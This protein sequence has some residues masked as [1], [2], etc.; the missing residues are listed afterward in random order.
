MLILSFHYS[1]NAQYNYSKDYINTC[2]VTCINAT[3]LK[4]ADWAKRV[5]SCIVNEMQLSYSMKTAKEW[6]N[7]ERDEHLKPF[8]SKCRNQVIKEII[9]VSK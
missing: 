6:S 1:V 7:I 8:I 4:N 9:G 5:C 2:M 3:G